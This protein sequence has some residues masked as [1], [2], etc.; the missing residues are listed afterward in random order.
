MAIELVEPQIEPVLSTEYESKKKV[1]AR[2]PHATGFRSR[3]HL[4]LIFRVG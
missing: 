4:R 2:V 3:E 1:S